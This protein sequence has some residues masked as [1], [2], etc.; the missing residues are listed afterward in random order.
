M[1]RKRMLRGRV[2][3]GLL[4]VLAAGVVATYAAPSEAQCSRCKQEILGVTCKE[5][6]G[7]TEI[8]RNTEA[9]SNCEW[10]INGTIDI[11]AGVLKGGLSGGGTGQLTGGCKSTMKCEAIASCQSTT[12]RTEA[13]YPVTCEF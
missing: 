5:D 7:S 11:S 3:T 10:Q 13:F 6:K 4:A 12:C 1:E 2:V 8:C 9:V